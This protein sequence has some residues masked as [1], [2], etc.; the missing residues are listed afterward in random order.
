MQLIRDEGLTYDDVLL[1]PKYS[2]VEHRKDIN[3]STYLSPRVQMDLPIVASPMDTVSSPELMEVFTHYKIACP[4]HRFLPIEEQAGLVKRM[5]DRGGIPVGCIGVSGDWKERLHALALAGARAIIIDIA[6]GHSLAMRNILKFATA[7]YVD[8]DFIGGSIATSTAAQSLIEAGARAVRVG[9]GNGASCSTRL[10]TG[11]GVPQLT[12]ILDVNPTVRATNTHMIADGG[13][14]HIGDI[15]K[16]LA[17]GASSVMTGFM[18]AGTKEAAGQIININGEL[19]KIYRG[20]ASK[21]AQ[22]QWKGINHK[23]AYEEGVSGLVPHK[24]PAE[25]VILSI[26]KGVSSGLSYCGARSIS[27]LQEN[28]TLRLISSNTLL[29]NKTRISH[30]ARDF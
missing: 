3:L 24:G 23:Q 29:E 30:N 2:D 7:E 9:V 18:F 25:D 15:T 14:K 16:A 11:V 28:A 4:A 8:I 21:D 22:V 27:E 1:V 17:C 19:F 6:H 5:V 10:N 26:I 12:A 13:I 20:M